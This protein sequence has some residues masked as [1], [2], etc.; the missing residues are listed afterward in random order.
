MSRRPGVAAP[1]RSHPAGPL[2]P[3]CPDC[4]HAGC[5]RIGRSLSFGRFAGGALVSGRGE[6]PGI[7]RCAGCCLV[8][9]HP[10]PDDAA[11]LAR[12]NDAD[13]SVW[14]S[15]I[16]RPE[17]DVAEQVVLRHG[18]AGRPARVLDVGC[19][20]GSFL[21]RLPTPAGRFG[22]EV[23]RRAAARAQRIGVQV[24]PTLSAIPSGEHFDVVTCFD[25]IEHVNAPAA[26]LHDLLAKL[27]PGGRLVLS[28]GDAAA[29]MAER[30][31]AVNWYFANPEHLSFVSAQ[32]LEQA[33]QA[34]A[35]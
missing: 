35:G 34:L 11:G 3:A 30:R 4:R 27:K 15:D 26:F 23:N 17:F 29:F 25:V 1:G 8:F 20:Q 13:G 24:W 14:Q 31:P 32:W 33:L 7:Y 18:D 28:S 10:R 6:S 2:A 19:N 5:R 16:P 22:V 12:Y 9:K 21:G